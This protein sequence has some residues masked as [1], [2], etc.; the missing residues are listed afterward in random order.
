MEYDV[1]GEGSDG[2]ANAA[3]QAEVKEQADALR[4]A[5]KLAAK[6]V[7]D[8]QWLVHDKREL[9]LDDQ[10]HTSLTKILQSPGLPKERPS[11]MQASHASSID[12]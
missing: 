1:D 4:K 3:T 5:K 12:C 6:N 10:C 8:E 7:E 9:V 2:E 11:K